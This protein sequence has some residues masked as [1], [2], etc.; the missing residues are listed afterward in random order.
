M[1]QYYKVFVLSTECIHVNPII[2][3]INS[4]SYSKRKS[5]KVH[6]LLNQINVQFLT[7]TNIKNVSATCFG[8]SVYQL[9]GE[10]NANLKTNFH[11]EGIIYKVF[12]YVS[13]CLIRLARSKLSYFAICRLWVML[14]T[15]MQESGPGLFI[16][17]LI[18]RGYSKNIMGY[19]ISPMRRL[20]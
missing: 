12:L 18:R 17:Q 3:W 7:N 9:Q 10:Q 2:F 14:A 11:L 4:D 1:F 8:T 16:I 6:R 5:N 20:P 15:V 19:T 13:F